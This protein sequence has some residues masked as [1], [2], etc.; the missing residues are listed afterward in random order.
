V[1]MEGEGETVEVIVAWN[2]EEKNPVL[3]RFTKFIES[4]F[5]E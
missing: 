4:S 5:I 1:P 2:K 3:Q